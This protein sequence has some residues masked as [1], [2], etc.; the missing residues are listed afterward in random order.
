M[1]SNQKIRDKLLTRT[2]FTSIGEEN[3]PSQMSRLRIDCVIGDM[4]AVDIIHSSL[5]RGISDG[6]LCESHRAD[7]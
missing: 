2:S 7:K 3:F 1:G 6:I 4:K 5:R